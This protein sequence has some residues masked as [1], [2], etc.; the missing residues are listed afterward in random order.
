MEFITAA[1]ISISVLAFALLIYWRA[2]VAETK[3]KAK[4]YDDL[5][6]R[7]FNEVKRRILNSDIVQLQSAYEMIIQYNNRYRGQESFISN[8][9]DV[10][11]LLRIYNERVDSLRSYS[12]HMK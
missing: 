5:K 1:F 10:R 2:V 11:E 3:N 4:F 6:Q 12:D 8:G 9:N 7:D